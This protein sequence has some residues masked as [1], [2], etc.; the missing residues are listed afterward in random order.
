MLT[1]A[2]SFRKIEAMQKITLLFMIKNYEST[3][4]EDSLNRTEKP[5]L[6]LR[7]TKSFC[8]EIYKT[9]N[10]LNPEFMK[11]LFRLH[12]TNKLQ[13]EKYKFNLEIT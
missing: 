1:S 4:Y 5:N 9:L 6:N 11:D 7:R 13:R 2:K 8:I 3:Y 12:A 10:M